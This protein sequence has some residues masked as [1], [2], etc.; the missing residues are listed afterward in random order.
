MRDFIVIDAPLASLSAAAARSGHTLTPASSWR[1]WPAAARA[2]SWRWPRSFTSDA[3]HTF[4][5]RIHVPARAANPRSHGLSPPAC[6]RAATASWQD[7]RHAAAIDPAGRRNGR[8]DAG[9]RRVHPRAMELYRGRGP[10]RTP[11]RSSSKPWRSSRN[12]CSALERFYVRATD[13]SSPMFGPI[14]RSSSATGPDAMARA[15]ARALPPGGRVFV[16]AEAAT[17]R[18]RER[19]TSACDAN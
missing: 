4:P 9:A 3:W 7:H 10:R 16:T 19:G 1:F 5:I 14:I 15:I 6:A 17:P 12:T 8:S 11:M 18:V 2:C 13:L